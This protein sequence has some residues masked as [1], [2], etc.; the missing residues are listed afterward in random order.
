M[1]ILRVEHIIN[2]IN[3]TM[4]HTL[5]ITP[6]FTTHL[7]NYDIYRCLYGSYNQCYRMLNDIFHV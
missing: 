4:E 7:Y 2:N 5:Q 6:Y 3:N 1:Y